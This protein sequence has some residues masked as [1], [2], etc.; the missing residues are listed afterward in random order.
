MTNTVSM[1]CCWRISEFFSQ[2]MFRFTHITSNDRPFS[3]SF[4]HMDIFPQSYFVHRPQQ[5]LKQQWSFSNWDDNSIIASNEFCILKSELM[6]KQKWISFNTCWVELGWKGMGLW[7]KS[8]QV[9]SLLEVTF[10]LN[11]FCSNTI[12]TGL[13]E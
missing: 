4:M 12:L 2:V 6:Y 1:F 10:L 8:Y 11:L 5:R 13:P 9:Q 3:S 7:Q